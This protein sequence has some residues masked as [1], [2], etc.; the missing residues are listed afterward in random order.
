MALVRAG[1]AQQQAAGAAGGHQVP[2]STSRSFGVA[3]VPPFNGIVEAVSI[4][5]AADSVYDIPAFAVGVRV[6]R[7]NLAPRTT[8]RGPGKVSAII[9]LEHVMQQ[10]AAAVGSDPASFRQRH[11]IQLPQEALAAAAAAA[12]ADSSDSQ[13]SNAVD[14][15]AAGGAGAGIMPHPKYLPQQGQ[16]LATTLGKPIELRHYTLPYMWQQVHAVYRQRRPAVEAFN[17]SNRLRK[18]GLAVVP[19]ST[20]VLDIDWKQRGLCSQQW[21]TGRAER[22]VASSMLLLSILKVRLPPP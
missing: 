16:A 4:A 6:A 5:Y 11:M 3:V 19:I 10:L 17:G 18:R 14:A 1:T 7:C 21:V 15:A 12:A 8:M 20:A 2:P 9:M 22:F 13:N